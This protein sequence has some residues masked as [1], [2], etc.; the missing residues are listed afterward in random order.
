MKQK[1]MTEREK[2]DITMKAFALEDEG[3][4]EEADRLLKTIPIPAYLVKILKEQFGI[5]YLISGG[6]NLSEAEAEFGQEWLAS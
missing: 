2:A 1:K 4:K 3:K 5:D 6:Y